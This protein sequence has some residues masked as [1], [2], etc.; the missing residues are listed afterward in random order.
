MASK[1]TVTPESLRELAKA[2]NDLILGT[3]GNPPVLQPVKDQ[4]GKVLVKAGKFPD[5][6]NME[7]TV[8][9]SANGRAKAYLTAANGLDSALTT[10]AGDLITIADKYANTDDIN[11]ITA[12]DINNMTSEV[13]PQLTPAVGS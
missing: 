2:I 13:L 6:I 11:K 4:L 9:G 7:N 10:L 3:A 1:I 12:T 8:A 5:G